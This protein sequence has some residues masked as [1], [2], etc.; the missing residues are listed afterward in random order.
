MLCV[1]ALLFLTG[2]LAPLATARPQTANAQSAEQKSGSQSASAAN[3]QGV[4]PANSKDPDTVTIR[5]EITAGEKDK[6]VE[7][8]SVYVRYTEPH[9]IK[10]DRKVE[11][12][13]K[14]NPDGH[15]KVPLVPRGK[16]LIQVIAEGWKTFGKYFD[17]D[18]DEQVVKIHLDRP[19]KWY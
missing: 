9:K 4:K 8:A 11:M 17:V 7:N 19:T 3:P 14:T 18:Q 13:V 10:R 12:N 6:P 15:V 16:I 2:L 5:I 1:L